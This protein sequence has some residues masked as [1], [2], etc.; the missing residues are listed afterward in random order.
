LRK[1]VSKNIFGILNDISCRNIGIPAESLREH[2]ADT[3]KE[4]EYLSSL[5]DELRYDTSQ[6]HFLLK[7]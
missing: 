4:K 1:K 7:Q 6:Y 5:F 3:S 2:I